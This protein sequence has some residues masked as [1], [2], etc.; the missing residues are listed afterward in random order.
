MTDRD[1]KQSAGERWRALRDGLGKYRRKSLAP[2]LQ[3]M[4]TILPLG[5]C[6]GPTHRCYWTLNIDRTTVGYIGFLPGS[7][8][9]KSSSHMT[10]VEGAG[11]ETLFAASAA[12]G[13]L[14]NYHARILELSL[15]RHPE[16]LVRCTIGMSAM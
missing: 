12:L 11:C 15:I 9:S 1:R 6:L 13:R 7:H 4:I 14:H 16:N 5:P 3:T 8:S 2:V 10:Q